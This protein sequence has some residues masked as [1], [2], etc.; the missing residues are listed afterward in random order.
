MHS[1]YAQV[2]PVPGRRWHLLGPAIG[3]ALV[4]TAGVLHETSSALPPPVLAPPVL[5]VLS[6]VEILAIAAA[7]APLFLAWLRPVAAAVLQAVA[8]VVLVLV[9]SIAPWGVAGPVVALALAVGLHTASTARARVLDAWPRTPVPPLDESAR[10]AVDHGTRPSDLARAGIR[11]LAVV[12]IGVGL[13]W[14]GLDMAR[15]HG[16]RTDPR[17]V[18][19]TGTV[20]ELVEDDLYADLDVDGTR[21]RVEVLTA[22]PSVGDVLPVRANADRERAELLGTPFDPAGALVWSALGFAVLVSLRHRVHDGHALAVAAR[23]TATPGTLV[24]TEDDLVLVAPDGRGLGRFD[25]LTMLVDP[26]EPE[27]P[28]DVPLDPEAAAETEQLLARL[29]TLRERPVSELDNSELLE[30]YRAESRLEELG[31][32]HD[33]RFRAIVAAGSRTDVRLH[34]V[35]AT[36]DT[37]VRAA[38]VL[39]RGTLLAPARSRATGPGV[40]GLPTA[41]DVPDHG[42]LHATGPLAAASRW[43]GDRDA[44]PMLAVHAAAAAAVWWLLDEPGNGWWDALRAAVIPAALLHVT[45]LVQPVAGLR[46]SHLLVREPVRV[47]RI[48][49]HEV[50]EI[51]SHDETV[52][53]RLLIDGTS[54][55]FVLGAEP[56]SAFVPLAGS[57]DAEGAATLLRDAWHAGRGLT[58]PGWRWV[59]STLLLLGCAWGV[60]L[61]ASALV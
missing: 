24:R 6:V 44:L 22:P 50:T 55:A 57:R 28:D 52:I 25:A 43:I 53:V 27:L 11:G 7:F 26:E 10:R 16:F 33:P 20:L 4:T 45:W 60:V 51:A 15:V 35:P 40:G 38:G 18:T 2:P 19:T 29:N 34:V 42:S 5:P 47:Q 49:W 56:G 9:G 36:G 54:D 32:T 17:T 3:A 48:P 23:G 39:L 12:L 30:V 41:P 8:A 58:M 37:I 13:V 14:T 1:A 61:V 21:F 59:P 31:E 46:R